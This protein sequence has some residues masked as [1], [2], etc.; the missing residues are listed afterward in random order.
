MLEPI[1]IVV[2]WSGGKDCLLMLRR[3]Q[4]DPQY[5]I[6]GLLT[7]VWS[8]E[9]QVAMHGVPLSL[10]RAQ[11]DALGFD[12]VILEMSRFP[13]N[14]EYEAALLRT[15]D[16]FRSQGVQTIAFGDLF[17]ADIR[18]YRE[19]L[20][21]RMGLTP[22]FPLWSLPTSTLAEEF[23]AAGYR[24]RICCTDGRLGREAVGAEYNA[25]F[26]SALRPGID[27]CGENGEF[28][29]FV[30]DGPGFRVPVC[31]ELVGLTEADGFCW[32]QWAESERESDSEIIDECC[33]RQAVLAGEE[34]A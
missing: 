9:R 33:D 29:T 5:Q 28:H 17:L 26:V 34:I 21:D 1:P 32:A 31:A 19:K 13:S 11:T 25:K 30:T 16:R 23:I 22:L 10:L 14:R 3:L 24:A 20:C 7:T 15:M 2:S 12:G 27:P 6:A 18:R 8:R 4:A